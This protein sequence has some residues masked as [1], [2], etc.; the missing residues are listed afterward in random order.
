MHTPQFPESSRR[1]G[2]GWQFWGWHDNGSSYQQGHVGEVPGGTTFMYYR[3]EVNT[4]VIFC[5]NQYTLKRPLEF[6]A[7]L[8]IG[9][10]LFEI[11]QIL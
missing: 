3:S 9:R 1:F 6:V 5:V 4:G 8:G 2:F 10:T 11:A 7:W